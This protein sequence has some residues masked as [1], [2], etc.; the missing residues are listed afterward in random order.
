MKTASLNRRVLLPL[1]LIVSVF[2][3]FS[4]LRLTT[5]TWEIT[6][7]HLKELLKIEKNTLEEILKEA[8]TEAD[9]IQKLKKSLNGRPYHYLVSLRG[10]EI[11]RSTEFP[12]AYRV[13]SDGYIYSRGA[14]RGVV[15]EAKGLKILLLRKGEETR[16]LQ[17]TLSEVLFVFT[18]TMLTALLIFIAIFRR[19]IFVP[20]RQIGVQIKK[21]ECAQPT[22]I[23]ELDEVIEVVN[24]A[25]ATAELKHFQMQ[26]LHSIAVSLNEDRTMDE[27]MEGILDKARRLLGAEYAAFALYD[28]RGRFVKL[29]VS[30]VEEKEALK[31][32]G[33]LPEGKGVLKLMQL[34]LTPVRIDD[35]SSHP[36]FSGGF[37]EDHPVVRSFLGYPV[38]SRDGRPLG[39]LYF[40]N[41]KDGTFT[42]EDEKLLMAIA[43]DVAVAVQRVREEEELRRFKEIIDSAFDLIVVTDRAGSIVY[44]N[45][46]FEKVTGYRMEEIVSKNLAVLKSDMQPDEEYERLWHTILSGNHWRGELINKK[47]NGE[48][49]ITSTVAFPI[50]TEGE[51]S[52]FVCIQRDITEEKK[53]YEQLLRAQK[54]EAIGTLAGGI[55]HDFNNIMS[56]ILGYSEILKEMVSEDSSLYRPIDVIE[57]AAQR[58]ASLATKILTVVKKERMEQKVV[59]LNTIVMDTL[60]ILQRSIPRE[61]EIRVQLDE[62][63]P[64]VKAD[65][66]QLQQV[67]INLALNARDAMPEG[68]VLTIA[69]SKVG[70]SYGASNGITSEE[71]FVR[72]TVSDTGVGIEKDLQSR[73][74]D[75]FFTTKDKKAGTGLGLY[76]V[77]SI[78]TNHGGYI[79][80]YSEPG[81]GSRF[82]IYLPVYRGPEEEEEEITLDTLKGSETVLVIDDEEEL[83]NLTVDLL[84]PMGYKVITAN[85]G[86]EG[87]SLYRERK[88]EIDLV[89]LDMVMPKMS[90][91]EVFQRLKEINPQV[92]VLICSGYT[93]EGYTGIK[94]LLAQGASGFVQKPFTRLSIAREIRKALGGSSQDDKG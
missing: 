81:K 19:Y 12:H 28:E 60:E 3:I 82:N 67:I 75:P 92:R 71:G 9:A 65:P 64:P 57:K 68:G 32:V 89:V 47:K 39:A 22:H 36:A 37:P 8:T 72:L 46:I 77:H 44:V 1:I 23:R 48:S 69:T 29:R 91:R 63:I 88:D 26:T 45:R 24:D 49:F 10:E 52:H 2:F 6:D 87:I 16:T 21:G 5:I 59:N 51:I 66:A 93:E 84:E 17:R 40:A 62:E 4:F 33:R 56:I 73:V 18:L 15:V 85:G 76:I 54:M 78:V 43:S 70:N 80:L 55:A 79:N 90:G 35:L 86:K 20:L 58:G 13:G 14:L 53:L 50:Y 30:G 41:K 31:K 74:F 11:L 25:L 38:F 34:S 7:T 94:E 42:E 27:V 83:L 61:I